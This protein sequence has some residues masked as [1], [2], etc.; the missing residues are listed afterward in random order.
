MVGF[1]KRIL[2]KQDW[3]NAVNYT[4]TSGSGKM[5]LIKRLQNL[6]DNTKI[7]VLKAASKD[8]K[9]EDQTPDDYEAVD[10]PGCE[11]LRLGFTDSELDT[12]I[13][14]LK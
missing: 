3:Y 12:L 4:K 7:L 5:D 13:G 1:P 2:T 14:G 8:K 10:D 6:K 9:P 11:K